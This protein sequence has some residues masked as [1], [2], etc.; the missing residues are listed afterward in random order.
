VSVEKGNGV[1]ST[2]AGE[3]TV[4][5]V[6]H[7]EAGAHEAGEIEDRDA[8]AEREGRVGVAKVVGG[9]RIGAMPV[10]I[11]ACRQSRARK[12]CRSM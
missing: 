7:R 5:L 11:C 6:D 8:G 4:V 12:L 3:V 9:R 1:R 2:V 10:T